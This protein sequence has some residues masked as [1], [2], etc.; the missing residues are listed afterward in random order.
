MVAG[1][2][3]KPKDPLGGASRF[4][5]VAKTSK[6][7]RNIG[8]SNSGQKVN[9]GRNTPI[10]NPFQRGETLRK[11]THPT[12]KPIQLMQYLVR[13]VT[14]PNGLVL[15]CFLG[16]GSTA[17]AALKEGFKFIGIEKNKE[18]VEIAMARLKP[19]LSQKKLGEYTNPHPDCPL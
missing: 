1:K 18:Y 19:F 17:I 8:L 7:E 12:V 4:F 6:A 13:L 9:D 10:D 2:P 5:Y 16:S 3:S 15:D 14:P 11:N